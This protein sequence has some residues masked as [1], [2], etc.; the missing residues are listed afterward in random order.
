MTKY[1]ELNKLGSLSRGKSKHRPRNDKI[2]FENG[3][4]PFIQTSDVKDAY[5]Y[6]NHADTFYNKKG[7]AQS[8]LWKKDT[9]CIT[10]AANIAET[11]LLGIEACFPDSI[12]GFINDKSKCDIKYIKYCFDVLK[13]TYQQVSH[14]TSQENL[15]I[16]NLNTLLIPY[17][18]LERQH[19][20]VDN[21]TK[22]EEIYE[23]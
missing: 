6:I 19:H 12:V 3:D 2:L 13:N 17:V 14:G 7:L 15:N 4:I 18:N 10:I 11:A 20:I 1:V 23:N 5:L 21:I 8:Y 22:G 9:L 16:E